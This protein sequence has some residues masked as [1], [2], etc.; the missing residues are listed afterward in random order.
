VT[1][2]VAASFPLKDTAKAFELS[3]GGHVRGKIAIEV[4]R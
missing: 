4:S 2:P 3:Q 1:V